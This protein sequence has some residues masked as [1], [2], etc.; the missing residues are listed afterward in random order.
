MKTITNFFFLYILILNLLTQILSQLDN[1]PLSK[2]I[3]CITIVNEEYEKSDIDAEF[4]SASMLKC[5]ITITE[6]QAYN[7]IV[8]LGKGQKNM[9]KNERKKLL[10]INSLK[11]MS[12]RELEK[13]SEEMNKALKE[14]QKMQNEYMGRRSSQQDY[15]IGDYDDYDDDFIGDDSINSERHSIFNYLSLIPR[16]IFGIISEFFSYLYFFFILALVYFILFTI[17]KMGDNDK[18]KNRKQN[19]KINEEDYFDES[20]DDND[21]NEFREDINNNNVMNKKKKKKNK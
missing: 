19:D 5:Y 13:K 1:I 21:D 14:F 6:K 4:Y 17:R 18:N 15:D 12:E 16:G 9:N 10:D 11:H 7:F 20:D 2:I 8:S 3:A